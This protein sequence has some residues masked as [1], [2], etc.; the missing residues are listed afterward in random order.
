MK[1]AKVFDGNCDFPIAFGR[2]TYQDSVFRSWA[3]GNITADPTNASH[4]AVVW[5]DMR[6]TA[7]IPF[8]TCDFL[9]GKVADAYAVATNSDPIVSQSF[10]GGQTWSAATAIPLP[11]DQFQ[12]WSAF[13]ASGTLRIG[14]FDRSYDSANHLYGYSLLTQTGPSSFSKTQVSTVLSNPTSGDRWFAR[15]VNPAFPNAT[16]FLGDYSN[17]AV[18]PG[19]TSVVAYWTDMREDATF[20]GVTRKGEDAF[21]ALIP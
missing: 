6:N 16:A 19:T 5:Y 10:D 8:S 15:T 1:V 14:T 18:V 20:A 12:G 21:F 2:T 17:I 9:A 3:A 11:G 7:G 13:D 4:L